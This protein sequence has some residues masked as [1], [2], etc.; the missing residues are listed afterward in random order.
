MAMTHHQTRESFLVRF[1]RRP[2]RSVPGAAVIKNY[3]IFSNFGETKKGWLRII[4]SKR[5]STRNTRK[6]FL[7]PFFISQINVCKRRLMALLF[8]PSAH[9]AFAR[10]HSAKRCNK[11]VSEQT[12]IFFR[13]SVTYDALAKIYFMQNVSS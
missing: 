5:R 3:D 11:Q 13:G 8:F 2:E 10:Q 6:R 4:L 7:L 1:F 12:A 9:L